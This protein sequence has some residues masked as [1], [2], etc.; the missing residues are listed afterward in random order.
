[1]KIDEPKTPFIRYNFELD[2]TN[3]PDG[4][5][6][7][8]K[9]LREMVERIEN[10]VINHISS[11]YVFAYSIQTLLESFSLEG[12]KRKKAAL[13]HTPP[14]PSY[15][16][17]I[18]E[19][20]DDD[21]DNGDDNYRDP[22]EWQ[23]SDDENS[24]NNVSSSTDHDRF[25]MLRAEHYKMKEAMKQGHHIIDDEDEDEDEGTESLN[26]DL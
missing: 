22:D 25:A 3:D 24:G 12:S 21:D 13:A 8:Y 26:M 11:R 5:E 19:D 1:M 18:S 7:K 9:R 23:D 20:D 6:I 2:K 14:V 15:F 10:Y 17:G 16:P 4:N